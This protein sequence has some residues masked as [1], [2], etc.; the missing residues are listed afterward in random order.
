MK[1]FVIVGA[2]TRGFTMFAGRLLKNHR[3]ESEIV[4]ICDP[5]PVRSEYYK[6]NTFPNMRIYNDFELMLDIERPDGVI[7]ATVDCYHHEYIVKSLDRGYDVYTEKPMTT[8]VEQCLA[9][10][11]A[12]KRSGKRV[13]VTFNCRFMPY[14]TRIKE[15][16]ASGA[17]GRPL[18][19][20]YNYSLDTV[21]GADYFKRWHRYLANSGGMMVH[22][23]THHFDIA[24]WIIADEPKTVSATGARLFY[25]NDD[26]PHGERCT[27]CKYADT[28]ISYEDYKSHELMNGLYFN[29]EH[30]DGYVRDHCAYA[31]DTDIYDTMSVSVGYKGGAILSYSLSL[32]DTREGYDITIIGENGAIQASSFFEGDDYKIILRHRDGTSEEIIFPRA[33]GTHAGGDDRLIDML[34]GS[35]GEDTL[36][37]CAGSFDG[38]KSVLIGIAANQSIKHGERV[39]LTEV[40]DKMR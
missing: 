30:I 31:P 26:R 6:A 28:C 11:E 25:G 36:G 33:E 10:I 2:S 8:E 9:V 37:R 7:I 14:Y 27:T 1:R 22:K 20:I 34:F 23:A 18:H 17:I 4:A 16:V 32:Y 29:A 15:L 38:V 12:E 35:G 40:L 21:H 5:N 13:Y 19:M 24:N 39:D 3:G